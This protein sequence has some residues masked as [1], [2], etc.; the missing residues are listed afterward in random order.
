MTYEVEY[1]R[2]V[3]RGDIPNLDLVIFNR[4]KGA[5]EEKITTSPE[6]FG[7]P[8]RESLRGY[9]SLRIGDYRIVYRTETHSVLI[10]AIDHRKDRLPSRSSARIITICVSLA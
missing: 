4:V 7:K 2:I 9:R 1:L 3:L 5:I 10:V 6:I 8:L